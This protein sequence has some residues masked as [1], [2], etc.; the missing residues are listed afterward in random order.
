MLLILI[1]ISTR[2]ELFSFC[3]KLIGHFPIARWLRSACSYVKR[4]CNGLKWDEELTDAIKVIIGKLKERLRVSDPV[5]G[6][7]AVPKNDKARIW[8]WCDH[9]V[10]LAVSRLELLWKLVEE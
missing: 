4:L 8:P 7:W 1:D 9:G 10:T 2:R 6:K 3:G 5:G